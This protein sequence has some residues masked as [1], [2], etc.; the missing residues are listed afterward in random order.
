AALKLRRSVNLPQIAGTNQASRHYYIPLKLLRLLG[1]I[2]GYAAIGIIIC[3]SLEKI[4]RF[5]LS[6]L[7]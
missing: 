4:F 3:Y 1:I 5:L 2:L 6:V 7:Y